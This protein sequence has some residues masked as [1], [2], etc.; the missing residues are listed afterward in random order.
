[1]KRSLFKLFL[2]AI[3]VVIPIS[4]VAQGPPPPPVGL[5]IDGGIAFLLGS[6][7]V[8]AVSKLNKKK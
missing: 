1:M 4:V 2:I 5:P 6:G 3:A 8:Y 7:L